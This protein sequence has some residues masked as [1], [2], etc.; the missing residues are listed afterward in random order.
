MIKERIR[1]VR[2]LI[3][4]CPGVRLHVL[5]EKKY[6]T[7]RM[8]IRFATSL[9]KENASQRT[10]IS[11]LLETNSKKYPT[12]QAVSAVLSDLYG[13]S[14]GLNVGK[15]GQ[16]HVV[17][18]IINIVNDKFLAE[19]GITQQGVDFLK[20]MLFFPNV[21]AKKFH[22]ATFNREKENLLSYVKS[23][24]ED[25]QSYSSLELQKLYFEDAFQKVPSFG[26]LTE[27]SQ[28]TNEKVYEAY[29]E[30][31]K[32]DQVDIFVIG[33]LTEEEGQALF[34]DFPFTPRKTPFTEVVYQQKE[35]GVISEKQE[36]QEVIQSKLNLAYHI[37]TSFQGTDYFAAVV[38]NGLFGGFP[39]SKLFLNVREKESLAYYASS[40]LDTLRSFLSVQTGIEGKNRNRV[41][42]LI[43]QQLESLQK[44][45]ISD[46]ELAQTK[47]NLKN[48]FL[49]QQDSQ[50]GQLELA[51]RQVL[52]PE[53]ALRKEEWLQELN[54]V[55]K[56]QVA[57]FAR[58]L[59]LESIYFLEGE[60]VHA[61]ELS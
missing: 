3:L 29:V 13:A 32:N 26:N 15:K 60:E 42:H 21:A 12:Q 2:P 22:E 34:A 46:L 1:E 36:R 24:Y 14:F 38:F 27:I 28:L 23:V 40:S 20:E 59:R 52:L 37:P 19:T 51:Y 45:E 47:G 18:A 58:T 43:D 41:L 50:Q 8:N 33:D 48:Q 53:S 16:L 25:K 17:T 9:K 5:T 57:D 44:G 56:E 10:L 7:I 35:Q 55:T 49:M 11:S 6:K 54:K 61:D 39:H 31:L 30:M 4:L